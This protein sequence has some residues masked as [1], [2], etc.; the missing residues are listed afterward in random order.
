MNYDREIRNLAGETLALQRILIALCSKAASLDRT[1]ALLVGAA[2]DEA[3]NHLENQTVA[4]GQSVPSEHLA[5]SLRVIEDMR[6]A[7]LGDEGEQKHR[8]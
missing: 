1:A 5:H 6:T 8:V 7:T 4:F 3:A 2:F